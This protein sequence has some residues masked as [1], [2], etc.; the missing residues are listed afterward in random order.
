[1]QSDELRVRVVYQGL[2][3]RLAQQTWVLKFDFWCDYTQ[4]RMFSGLRPLNP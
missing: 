4:H 2:D 3:T 1:M